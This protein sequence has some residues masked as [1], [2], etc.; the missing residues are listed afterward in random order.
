MMSLQLFAVASNA[1][2]PDAGARPVLTLTL[3]DN[4]SATLG[5]KAHASWTKLKTMSRTQLEFSV[6]KEADSGDTFAMARNLG[7]NPCEWCESDHWLLTTV[8]AHTPNH[9]T[10]PDPL[11]HPRPYGVRLHSSHHSPRLPRH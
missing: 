3:R 6:Q 10:S 4:A 5:R 7:V 2:S 11:S 9:S 8:R 1:S